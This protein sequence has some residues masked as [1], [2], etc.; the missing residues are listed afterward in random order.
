MITFTLQYF[1][2]M[3]LHEI[4]ALSNISELDVLQVAYVIFISGR[5]AFPDNVKRACTTQQQIDWCL[6]L[7]IFLKQTKMIMRVSSILRARAY[8]DRRVRK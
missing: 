4:I 5:N 1:F 6:H 7:S 3:S 2:S 8:T